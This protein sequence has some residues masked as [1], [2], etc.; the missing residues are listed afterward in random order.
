MGRIRG[1]KKKNCVI[2]DFCPRGK[3]LVGGDE[4]EVFLRTP[5]RKIIS[6]EI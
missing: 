4:E 1:G 6:F 3:L 2:V 5:V